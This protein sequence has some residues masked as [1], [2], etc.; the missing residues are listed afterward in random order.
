MYIRLGH[1]NIQFLFKTVILLLLSFLD[2]IIYRVIWK[3]DRNNNLVSIYDTITS[4]ISIL[5]NKAYTII[6]YE[7]NTTLNY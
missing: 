6:N 1:D 7:F 5:I 3:K 4:W 2:L